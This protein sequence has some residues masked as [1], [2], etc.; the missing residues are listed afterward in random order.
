MKKLLVFLLTL[1]LCTSLFGC[2][3]TGIEDTQSNNAQSQSIQHTETTKATETTET[4]K[5]TEATKATEVTGSTEATEITEVT[6]VTNETES[7]QEHPDDAQEAMV[8]IP[9]KGGTK[10]HA[11]EKCSGMNGPDHITKSQAEQLGFTPCKKCY[12]QTA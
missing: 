9:T 11:N 8:W 5:A 7:V 4:T 10:Y 12:K 3:E 6:E 1:G 2:A